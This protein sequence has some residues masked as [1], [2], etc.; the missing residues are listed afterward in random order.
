LDTKE[1]ILKNMGNQNISHPIDLIIC[2]KTPTMEVK[3]ANQSTVCVP[4]FFKISFVFNRRQTNL[5]TID[6]HCVKKRLRYFLKYILFHRRKKEMQKGM[7][8]C[9]GE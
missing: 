6:F 9:E 7:N 2:G 4:L 1:D 8:Q 5:V 3:G